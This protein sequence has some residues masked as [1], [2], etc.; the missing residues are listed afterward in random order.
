[1]W[2]PVVGAKTYELQV[3]PNGDWANNLALDVTV[4]STR[5]S[6]P[7]TLDTDQYFWRVRAMDAK[8]PA[9]NGGW[10]LEWQFKRAW[11]DQPVLLQPAWNL[12]D[13]ATTIDVPTFSW[14]PV[15]HAS[16][17][18]LEFSEDINFSPGDPTTVSCFTN[19]T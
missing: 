4:E 18:E 11:S 12:G 16:Y 13:P 8:S 7:T 10:S 3:S 2:N 9:N 17:Y 14:T 15:H 19:H 6:P 5:Y 1:S